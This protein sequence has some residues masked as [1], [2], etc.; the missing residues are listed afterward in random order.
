MKLKIFTLSVC[1]LSTS[2][3][4]Y[5]QE[6]GIDSEGES[7]FNLTAKKDARIEITADE[8][9]SF[10]K[11][12]K[13]NKETQYVFKGTTDPTV[14]KYTGW[15][16][17]LSILNSGEEG[18][19]NLKDFRPGVGLKAGIVNTLSSITKLASTGART[20]GFNIAFDMDNVRLY[21]TGRGKERTALPLTIGADGYY[22]TIRRGNSGKL[23]FNRVVA[24]TGSIKYTSNIDDMPSYQDITKSIPNTPT[25]IVVLEDFKGKYGQIEYLWKGRAS[26]AYPMYFHVYKKVVVNPIPYVAYNAAISDHNVRIGTFFNILEDPFEANGR[27]FEIPS[28]IGV[29]IDWNYHKNIS[30]PTLAIK[31]TI[32]L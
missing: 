13:W 25:N 2:I 5:S 3:Y 18:I 11:I 9:L 30:S 8:P 23:P 19:I 29:G 10:T 7:V 21:D 1:L 31:G 4:S 14:K 20:S 16:F 28:S 27:D 12:V 24:F 6:V 32:S 15:L 26:V 22:N 17:S